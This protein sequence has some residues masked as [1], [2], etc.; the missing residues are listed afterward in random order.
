MILLSFDSTT[1]LA[2]TLSSL[3]IAIILAI[4][5][6]K[7][8]EKQF[9]YE[10]KL[11]FYL[12]FTPHF[13]TL[14]AYLKATYNDVS[15]NQK[16]EIIHFHPILTSLVEELSLHFEAYYGRILI[17]LL[18]LLMNN[19]TGNCEK[20][21]KDEYDMFIEVRV[22]EIDS[23]KKEFN[24]KKDSIFKQLLRKKIL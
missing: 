3:G 14:I 15:P 7:I 18:E 24:Y 1:F 9:H 17:Q 8:W 12:K 23:I 11:E 13:N 22:D 5:G 16:D 10:K 2:T 4:L 20:M 21:K 19:V 6:Y